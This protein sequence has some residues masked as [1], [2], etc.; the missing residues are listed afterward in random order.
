VLIS[1]S[2]GDLANDPGTQKVRE[3]LLGIA[4]NYFQELSNSHQVS[5]LRVADSAYLLGRVQSSLGLDDQAKATLQKALNV[6]TALLNDADDQIEALAKTAATHKEFSRIAE[7]TWSDRGVMDADAQAAQTA[8]TDSL[9]HEEACVAYRRQAVELDPDDDE[10]QR[11][12]ANSKMSLALVLIKKGS[13]DPKSQAFAEADQLLAEACNTWD[14]LL[15][16]S[17]ENLKLLKDSARGDA[18]VAKLRESQANAFAESNPRKYEKL[19]RESLELRTTAAQKF[20]ELPANAVTPDIKLMQANCYRV[21]AESYF[22]LQQFDDAINSY[23]QAL[24][25]LRSLLRGSP[26]VDSYREG[27]AQ[28]QFMLAQLYFAK[29]DNLGYDYTYEFQKTLVEGLAI[30]PHDQEVADLLIDYTKSIS[31]SFVESGL[32]QE[33]LNQLEQ[34]K[35]LLVDV[36]ITKADKPLIDAVIE[37]LEAEAA[38]L[39]K[40]INSEDRTA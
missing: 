15:A 9:E 22:Q 23:Q 34:A 8:L 40:K 1:V 7:K 4:Q 38:E 16:E 36:P 14:E 31:V 3:R 20:D 29:Q 6:Q 28:A 13:W 30:N 37:E 5:P 24:Q 26:L 19:L 11:L 27:V 17:P 2:E 32:F 21:C 25:V 12:L 39:R 10:L 35:S 18:A 33:A